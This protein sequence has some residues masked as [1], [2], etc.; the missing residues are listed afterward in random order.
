MVSIIIPTLNPSNSLPDLLTSLEHQTIK[1]KDVII[2]DSSST[3]N[4]V[5]IARR[6]NTSVITIPRVEFGKNRTFLF[7]LDKKP[8]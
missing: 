4:T 7:W 8:G 1:E 5:A 3:D 6:Y 2:I